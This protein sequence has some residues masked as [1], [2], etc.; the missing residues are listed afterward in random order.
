MLSD[1]GRSFVSK[2]TP[3][4]KSPFKIVEKLSPV[5]FVLET[6]DSRRNNKVHVQ[7]LKRFMPSRGKKKVMP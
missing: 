2:L 4:F 6:G 7:D 5:I 1:D 3:T